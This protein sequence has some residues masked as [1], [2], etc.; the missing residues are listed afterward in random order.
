MA[1]TEVT[2]VS[3]G[4]LMVMKAT[5]EENGD[6]EDSNTQ[7]ILQLQPI[8]AGMDE[9]GETDTA[10]V[11]VEAHPEETTVDGE[12]VELGYPITCGECKA[13]LLVKKFV[14]PGINVKCVKYEDQLISPKQFVHMSG[15]ATLKDWKRAIRMGGVMLR[16]MM[17]SGQLDFYE[18]ST[19]CTNTCRSTKFDLLI[20][21]TRFPPDGSGLT[22]PISSQ[23]QVV[24]GNG[25]QVAMTT[26][27]RSDVL[28]GTV[29][30]SSGAVAMETEKKETSEI[31]EET[32]NFWKGIADVGLMGEVV[33]NIRT[34]LLEMLRGVQLRSEQAAMQDAD[35]CLV[36]VAVLSN[37]AQVFGLLDSVKH[38]LNVRRE[39]TDPGEEQVLST[40]TNLE[41]QL[42]EQRRQQHV[43]AQLCHP[44]P[45][46][47]ISHTPGGK[48]TKPKAKR[49]RLQ[50]PASTTTLLTSSLSQPQTATL[51]PQ[52]FTV[53]S[54]IS[55][56]SM[57]Q[58]FSLSGL[59][60]L[61]GLPMT[62][63]G[64]QNNTVT[65]HTLPAG[66]QTF[67]RYITTM[68]GADGKMETLTLHPSQGLTLVGTTLQ[69]PSQ[70]G[71]TMMSPL[72]LVQ[73][74]QGGVTV[75]GEMM[76]EQ[77]MGQVVEGGTMVLHQEGMVQEGLVE[78]VEDKS[79][80][81]T[82]TEI[83]PA[84]GDQD[85]TMGAVMELQLAQEGEAEAGEEGSAMVVHGGMEVTMVSE[86][87][88]GEVGEGMVVQG[89]SE[90]AQGEVL[91]TG[92]QSQ[93]EGI[94]L[95]ANGQ[96]SG[97]RIMVIEEETQEE[98][99]AK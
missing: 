90:D 84:P 72:E 98:D 56:S 49:P 36:E 17:D 74:T 41:L 25:G 81:Q 66:A 80:A 29:E 38:I 18:H 21:N 43:R 30:W 93:V 26:E 95:D 34:E 82:V 8:T 14:C 16:K 67:T 50:R 3:M 54:P 37:L 65:L 31:S 97:L 39:Q 64:Q 68:V 15:K 77:P 28:T 46:N 92:Q 75:S 12:E 22:T 58:P 73:L 70:L 5:E 96:I 60:G 62:T 78:G 23:A 40:L 53:L 6:D 42:E 76:V 52:Q 35:S 91:E 89:E 94:Q 20:N 32:L 33:D 71:G 24:I 55:F 63:L 51:Q 9:S 48:P 69:D 11:A 87:V 4:D 83:D 85:Q 88:E 13:V 86:E 10:V 99:K 44:Q 57:G 61:S 1:Q 27:E 47:N 79:Q 45:L 19:L 59:S 2:T 7:V